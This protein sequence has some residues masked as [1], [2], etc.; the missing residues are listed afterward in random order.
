MSKMAANIARL[1]HAI[2]LTLAICGIAS[3]T[4]YPAASAA[5][6]DVAAAVANISA[7]GDIVTVPGGTVTW[8]TASTINMPCFVWTLKG[9]GSASTHITVNVGSSNNFI[10]YSGCTKL[11]RVTGFHLT[12]QSTAST[13]FFNVNLG[14]GF[15]AGQGLSFRVDNSILDSTG[16]WGVPHGSTRLA[17]WRVRR[18]DVFLITIRSQT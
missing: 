18:L 2:V 10:A 3:A 4:T 11:G 16:G 7:D 12:N 9:A 8:S 5:Q 15:S 1:C 17:Q 6:S 13:G 14:S